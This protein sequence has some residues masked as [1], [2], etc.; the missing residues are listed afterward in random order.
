MTDAYRFVY[1]EP[2]SNLKFEEVTSLMMIADKYNA[3]GLI[4]ICRTVILDLMTDTNVVHVAILGHQFND[5]VL[6]ESAMERMANS[7]K[8]IKEVED[9]EILKSYP[10]LSFDLLEYFSSVRN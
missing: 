5:D 6:K 2:L 4:Q 1:G 10:E 9:S 8:N 3:K 7:G